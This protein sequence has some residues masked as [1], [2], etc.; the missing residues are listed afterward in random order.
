MDVLAGLDPYDRSRFW[1]HIFLNPPSTFP[2]F[3][4]L[5]LLP[6]QLGP[7][8][9]TVFNSILALLIVPLALP[10][11]RQEFGGVEWANRS[12]LEVGPLAVVFALSAACT[13]AIDTGQVALLAAFLILLAL[14]YRGRRPFLAG[15]LLALS[16]IKVNTM[17]PFLLLFL[18]RRDRATWVSC[19][20]TTVLLLLVAGHPERLIDQAQTMLRYVGMASQPGWV[21]DLTLTGSLHETI[22]GLDHALYRV[23]IRDQ[24]AYRIGQA[25]I[26]I[27]LGGWLARRIW[28]GALAGGLAVAIVSLFSLLFLYHRLYDAVIIA[29][30]LLLAF[31]QA[32][33][34][35]GWPRYLSITAFLLMLSILYMPA[36]QLRALADLSLESG[37]LGRLVQATILPYATWATLLAIGCLVLADRLGRPARAAVRA[38][39]RSCPLDPPATTVGRDHRAP[40]HVI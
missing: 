30:A 24:N 20:V 33:W 18:R 5:A 31:G 21:N 4:A 27:A 22:I 17:A 35:R 9:W 11:L 29:P 26:L 1:H 23:G 10:V 2:L 38:S 16:S 32:T 12:V 37:K 8:I 36:R 34:S 15:V 13:R 40:P 3:A 25:I 28:T 7:M 14:C 19:A 6:E 39:I